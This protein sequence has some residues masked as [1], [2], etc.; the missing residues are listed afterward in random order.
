MGQTA[1]LDGTTG[2][3]GVVPEERG[4][5]SQALGFKRNLELSELELLAP[6]ATEAKLPGG[7]AGN[8][9]PLAA[10]EDSLLG[11][12]GKIRVVVWFAGVG[13]P[14]GKIVASWKP[15]PREGWISC[16][17]TDLFNA[18]SVGT[19]TGMTTV[20]GCDEVRGTG[21]LNVAT[22]RPPGNGISGHVSRG[23]WWILCS[24]RV[25]NLLLL[26]LLQLL[27]LQWLLL[28]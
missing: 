15:P 19:A 1:S 26:Q 18:V 22:G 17:S 5:K 25:E 2:G 6:P 16:D 23:L 8:V 13:A 3:A 12:V 21:A 24:A 10:V 11:A 4:I 9:A 28:L 27:Q 7:V 20:W 14:V